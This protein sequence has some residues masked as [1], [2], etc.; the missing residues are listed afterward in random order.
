MATGALP[1]G[2]IAGVAIAVARAASSCPPSVVD[3]AEPYLREPI[4]AR[5]E[6]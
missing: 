4:A 5:S 1:H 2:T 6:S 3:D